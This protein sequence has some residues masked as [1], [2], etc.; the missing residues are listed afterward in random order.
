[1]VILKD[2]HSFNLAKPRAIVS[3]RSE[4]MVVLELDEV[5]RTDS[6]ISLFL[7][8]NQEWIFF[9]LF[10]QSKEILGV[11]SFFGSFALEVLAEVGELL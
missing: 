10:K 6:F 4:N 7:S 3:F 2:Q 9:H 11:W 1:M 8:F 5:R